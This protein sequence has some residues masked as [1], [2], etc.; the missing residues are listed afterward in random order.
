VSQ[1]NDDS[2]FVLGAFVGNVKELKLFGV[3]ADV[4]AILHT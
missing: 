1:L 2:F 4:D 3:E